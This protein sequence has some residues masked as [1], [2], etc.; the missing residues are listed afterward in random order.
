MR[1]ISGIH[2]GRRLLTVSGASTRPTTDRVKESVFNILRGRI[3]GSTVLD[4]FAGSGALGIECLSRGASEV[5]FCD[6][7][8]VAV[9]VINKN[10]RNIAAENCKVINSDYKRVL[11]SGARYDIIFIDAPYKS[12]LGE[13]ALEE[14]AGCRALNDGGVTVYERARDIGYAVPRGLKIYDSRNYGDTAVD[15]IEYE[16]SGT[17]GKL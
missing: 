10:L 16:E 15:F 17:D 14:I 11:K 13:A 5:V 2:R 4:L 1:I 8:R 7:N 6:N 12:G 9:E 3:S